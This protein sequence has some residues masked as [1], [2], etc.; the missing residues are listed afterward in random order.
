MMDASCEMARHESLNASFLTPSVEIVRGPKTATITIQTFGAIPFDV[1]LANGRGGL[2]QLL[3]RDYV[4]GDE[5]FDAKWHVGGSETTAFAL[6]AEPAARRQ[7]ERIGKRCTVR[8]EK[9][10]IE[11]VTEEK[12]LVATGALVKELFALVKR[13]T[14]TPSGVRRRLSGW[15]DAHPDE[16]TRARAKFLLGRIDPVQSARARKGTP[17]AEPGAVSIADDARGAIS[18]TEGKRV[19]PPG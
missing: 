6:L 8:V 7:L 10:R 16:K 13:L 11:A 3:Q 18:R 5:A 4:I 14:L 2:R 9:S 12:E 17:L 1:V 19:P 15:A